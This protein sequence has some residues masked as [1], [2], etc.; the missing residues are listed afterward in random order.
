MDEKNIFL[1]DQQ[2]RKKFSS[3]L[4][5][6]VDEVGRGCVA[7]PLVASAVIFSSKVNIKSLKESK[8]VTQKIREQLFKEILNSA[9]EVSCS[10]I[11]TKTI[12]SIGLSEANYTALRTAVNNLST[13][14]NIVIVDGY[15]IP[16]A[17]FQQYA[18]VHGDKKSA[19]VAAA[20]IVAKVV[21]DK[22]MSLYHK[23]MPYYN[24]V[25]H[26]GYA[27]KYH[28]KKI[29]EIGLSELH[30]YYAYKFTLH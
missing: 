17:D 22:I 8:S 19:V 9:Q 5:C 26:K 25:Q 3:E 1:F 24:F 10:I 4:L 14:V 6:G 30:R 11:P 29:F 18:I 12:N 21:R 2:L 7:G 16:K 20:S 15:K 23:I 27:T 28:R 13:K